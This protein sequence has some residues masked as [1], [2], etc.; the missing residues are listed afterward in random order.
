MK[1]DLSQYKSDYYVMH[2]QTEEEAKIFLD[3]LIKDH[4]TWCNG[5]SYKKTFYENCG[6]RTCYA[7]NQGKVGSID[8]YRE[9]GFTV[10]EFGDFE[11][12]D[13]ISPSDRDLKKFDNFFS[14]FAIS[15]L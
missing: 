4:R 11:W 12:E 10:L 14:Q 5:Q 3:I 9:K 15:K 1:L 8:W 7:F 6:N 13:D 2:C